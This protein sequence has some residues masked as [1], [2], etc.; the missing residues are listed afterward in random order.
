[1]IHVSVYRLTLRDPGMAHFWRGRLGA[2]VEVIDLS[3]PE[4]AL[5]ER[6]PLGEVD[7]VEPE[8]RPIGM[9]N[10]TALQIRQQTYDAFTQK[11]GRKFHDYE[12]PLE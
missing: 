9:A 8:E 3:G 11:V 4:D 10:A 1:V 7:V 2:S 12:R 6:V 5:P